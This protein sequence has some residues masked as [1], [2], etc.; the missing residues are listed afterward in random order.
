MAGR[1]LS[2]EL[3]GEQKPTGGRD[4]SAELFG[5]ATS[6]SPSSAKPKNTG[7]LLSSSIIRGVAGLAGLPGDAIRLLE[8]GIT[9]VGDVFGL[10]PKRSF[11]GVTVGKDDIIKVVE[12][13]TGTPLYKPE[14]T[15]E[16]YAGKAIEG[17]VSLP[18]KATQMG[19]GAA[20]GLL[21]EVGYDVGGVPGAIVGSLIPFVAPSIA[22]KSIGYVID[23]AKGRVTDIR[24]GKMLRDVAG[25]KLAGI[26]RATAA[27]PEL[28]AAR[29]AAGEKSDTWSALGTLAQRKRSQNFP[30]ILD[31]AAAQRRLIENAAGAPNQEM[32]ILAQGGTKG[33]LSTNVGP[34]LEQ[35]LAAANLAGKTLPRLQGQADRFAGAATDKVQDVRRFTAAGKRAD[36][37]AQNFFS[38]PGQPRIAG[39]YSYADE[40]S[41]RAEQVATK[42]ADGSLIFGE[43]ARHS[44][45]M[46]DSLAK[47]GFKP[48]SGDRILSKINSEIMTPGNGDIL[49]NEEVLRGLANRVEELTE[50]YG[51]QLDAKSLQAMRE[52]DID[53]VVQKALSGT[54]G[55]PKERMAKTVN[56]LKSYLDDAIE[57]AGGNGWKP[58]MKEWS[59]GMQDI[60]RQKMNAVALDLFDKDKAKLMSLA[61]GNEPD[62]VKQIFPV[63]AP[64]L[65]FQMGGK[66]AAIKKVAEELRRDA[67]LATRATRGEGNL[68]DIL[69]KDSINFRLPAL[70]NHWFAFGN[71]ALDVTEGMLNRK[72]MEK[73]YKAMESGKSANAA[74]NT[75]PT[76]QQNKVMKAMIEAKF[77]KTV[78]LTQ[79]ASQRNNDGLLSEPDRTRRPPASGLLN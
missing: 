4:L 14:S 52:T 12:K 5:A 75:L 13:V 72:T 42:S 57:S 11:K 7:D 29:A 39:K 73:V 66:D 48:V 54:P 9:S 24:T 35:E 32:A 28:T 33:T 6:P 58:A 63:G 2:A 62:L 8:S 49:L 65:G 74:L 67:D 22:A 31:E 44:Q 79:E 59:A 77:P 76:S 37:L 68:S 53:F 71:K 25:P 1:D 55:I 43:Q 34:K 41:K 19:I 16:R 70:I 69:S 56:S 30:D 50:K 64:V 38:A 3:F 40:L 15:P 23:L 26:N 60:N 45:M 27:N 18:G 47:H 21:G 36:D 20:S 46:A 17:A 10:V 78:R 51:G 61:A